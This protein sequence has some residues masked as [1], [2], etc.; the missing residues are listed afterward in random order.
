M[1][2]I[3]NPVKTYYTQKIGYNMKGK[4]RNLNLSYPKDTG[5]KTCTVLDR[6]VDLIKLS[7]LF[8]SKTNNLSCLSFSSSGKCSWETVIISLCVNVY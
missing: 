1:I 7:S 8:E 2:I 5:R 3:T 4:E 6:N